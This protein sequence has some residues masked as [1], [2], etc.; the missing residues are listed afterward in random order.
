MGV[1]NFILFVQVVQQLFFPNKGRREEF[2]TLVQYAAKKSIFQNVGSTCNA[3]F[4]TYSILTYALSSLTNL[5][6]ATFMTYY[7]A[8]PKERVPY[9]FMQMQRNDSQPR[10]Y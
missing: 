4:I 10:C 9:L 1:G 7:L 6:G 8:K 5:R 2:L 3:L